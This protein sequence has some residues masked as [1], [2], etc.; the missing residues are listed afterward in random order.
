MSTFYPENDYRNYLKHY[1]VKG[2]RWRHHKS[3]VPDKI[4]G[5]IVSRIHDM[6]NTMAPNR[7]PKEQY[8]TKTSES[9]NR[10]NVPHGIPGPSTH[11]GTHP[12]YKQLSREERN[13]MAKPKDRNSSTRIA[14]ALKPKRTHTTSDVHAKNPGAQRK[15]DLPPYDHSVHI[16]GVGTPS[17]SAWRDNGSGRTRRRRGPS[18]RPSSSS[19]G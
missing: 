4:R 5:G 7:D 6:G 16:D 13:L 19:R 11:G 10:A 14:D 2:M 12:E 9:I 15:P 17:R 1:G 3:K 18:R 8:R